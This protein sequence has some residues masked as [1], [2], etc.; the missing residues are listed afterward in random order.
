VT[1]ISSTEGTFIAPSNQPP[2]FINLRI[3][4]NKLKHPLYMD[5]NRT[6]EYLKLP[7]L[8]SILPSE[9]PTKDIPQQIII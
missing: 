1:V 6:L 9:L 4:N 7:E 5:T 2:G 8:H 3:T